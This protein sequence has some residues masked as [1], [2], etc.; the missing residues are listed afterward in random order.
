[1]LQYGIQR[2]DIAHNAASGM[3]K[4]PKAHKEMQTYTEDEI[5]QLL[6]VVKEDRNAH[7]W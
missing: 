7:V 1:M 4:A 3:K 6:R 2:G 5:Q